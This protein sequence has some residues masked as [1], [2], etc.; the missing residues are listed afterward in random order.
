MSVALWILAI[1]TN[2]TA[3]Q[4]MYHVWKATHGEDEGG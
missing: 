3:F 4:R 2:F 1:L